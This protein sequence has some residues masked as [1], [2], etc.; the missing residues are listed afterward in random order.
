[1]AGKLLRCLL[2]CV[3]VTVIPVAAS[4]GLIRNLGPHRTDVDVTSYPWS[5]VGKLYNETGAACSGV[6]IAKDRILTAAHCLFN[7]RS[8]RFVPAGAVHF[9]VGYRTGRYAVHARIS[10]YEVGAGFDP[11][12]Y[13]ETSNADWAVLTVTESLPSEIEPL[14]LSADIMPRG[15][16]AV[17]VGYPQDRA[18]AMTADRDCELRDKIDGGK[19]LLHTCRGIKGYSGAPILVNAGGEEVQV[20]GIQIAM[21][22]GAG[23]ETAI[24]L[25]AQVIGWQRRDVHADI[26]TPRTEVSRDDARVVTRPEAVPAY[27]T[28]GAWDEAGFEIDAASFVSARREQIAAKEIA[29]LDVGHNSPVVP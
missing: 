13:G 29:L 12:R 4:A 14:R 17:L 7:Y 26:L 5:A 19:F 24:A 18:H 6:V 1:M 23:M 20:A 10:S 2:L 15:T 25:P 21:R 28:V 11:L 9:L 8:R 3:L 16:K 22:V 27:E